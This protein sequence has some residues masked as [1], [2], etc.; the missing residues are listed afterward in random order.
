MLW[1]RGGLLAGEE[2][3]IAMDKGPINDQHVLIL[4]I[5]H[6]SNSLAL[7]AN[8]YAELE[9][10]LSALRSYFASKVRNAHFKSNSP[11]CCCQETVVK[12]LT[13]DFETI[14]ATN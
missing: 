4:P 1:I 7:S 10:Y 9:R 14:V 6:R 12:C 2:M 8:A 13:C 5:E 11:L 3:Y